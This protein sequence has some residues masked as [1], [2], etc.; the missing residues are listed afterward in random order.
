MYGMYVSSL[1]RLMIW[2]YGSVL[3]LEREYSASGQEAR[4]EY[5]NASRVIATTYEWDIRT[6]ILFRRSDPGRDPIR[7]G[8]RVVAVQRNDY[9]ELVIPETDSGLTGGLLCSS[10][11]HYRW[12]QLTRSLAFL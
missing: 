8:I 9:A 6:A 7:H 1:L 11:C 4:C 5:W 12:T 10:F 3:R 2:V